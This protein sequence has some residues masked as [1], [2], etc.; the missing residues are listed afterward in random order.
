[1]ST[2]LFAVAMQA[3]SPVARIIRLLLFLAF[4]NAASLI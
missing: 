3:S 1:M 2:N 4:V